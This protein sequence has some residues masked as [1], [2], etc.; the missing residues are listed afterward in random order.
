VAHVADAQRAGTK[1][2]RFSF[3]FLVGFL[4]V[5][6]M[7]ATQA[8]ANVYWNTYNGED[9]FMIGR[10]AA[11]GVT[12]AFINA[13][14]SVIAVA[15]DG[16]YIYWSELSSDGMSIVR[17]RVDRS[18]A[19]EPFVTNLSSNPQAAWAL[20]VD[21]GWMYFSDRLNKE[22][23]RASVVTGAVDPDWVVGVIDAHGSGAL[24]LAVDS[25]YIY[26]TENVSDNIGMIGRAS[27]TAPSAEVFVE[28]RPDLGGQ[29]RP[30]G[31]AVNARYVYWTSSI[32]QYFFAGSRAGQ[33]E[34]LPPYAIGRASL[35]SPDQAELA[36]IPLPFNNSA[37]GMAIDS[38]HIYWA[39]NWGDSVGIHEV[40]LANLDGSLLPSG[41]Q[42]EVLADG[43]TN[44]TSVAV[45]A[46]VVTPPPPTTT[47]PTT[48][49]PAPPTTTAPA[50]V[51]PPQ[52][53]AD[54]ATVT[55]PMT[56]TLH[57]R[58]GPNGV[59]TTYHFEYG[60]T[61]AYG[62]RSPT[63][64]A[65][66]GAG[67]AL[68]AVSAGLAGLAPHTTYHY[69]VDATSAGG[70]VK[71][72]DQT[73][74]TPAA[75]RDRVGPISRLDMRLTALTA[76]GLHAVGTTT[77]RGGCNTN[78]VDR[79]DRG[80]VTKVMISFALQNPQG[81]CLALQANRKFG[82]ALDCRVWTYMCVA[83]G[84]HHWTFDIRMKFQP[85]RYR[86]FAVGYDLR[87]NREPYD[88]KMRNGVLFHLK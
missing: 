86:V 42:I 13:S 61:T 7:G 83:K 4:I 44:P 29:V 72:G 88:P 14:G 49:T 68:S 21:N 12:R 20:A 87:G 48:T 45:D 6:L 34:I 75:C 15:S 67:T 70:T 80:G 84:R 37:Q 41:N 16:Q 82:R 46:A 54:P 11:D 57:G 22:I 26:W 5:G 64:D 31:I 66:A 56:A 19:A 39:D 74:T 28:L 58:V 55:G 40:W 1:R 47:T 36:F 69:R 62:Q 51:S 53:F 25:Q 43:L 8:S 73:F 30:V 71:S 52:A 17:E 76:T 50:K 65:S 77:D 85:G 23:R 33:H 81:R 24:G 59:A 38:Q 3:A 32:Q 2:W 78:V 35:Q 60:L 10:S 27:L 9:Q 18:S 63:A 79:R